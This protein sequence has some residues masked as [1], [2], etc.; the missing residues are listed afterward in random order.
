MPGDNPES[1]ALLREPVLR[2]RMSASRSKQILDAN[3]TVIGAAECEH[4]S[5]GPT[6]WRRFPDLAEQTW[7][8]RDGGGGVV[9]R[10]EGP[11]PDH[12]SSLMVT[13]KNGEEVGTITKPLTLA[14]WKR[15]DVESRGQTLGFLS[16]TLRTVYD[17][18]GRA[19][20]TI[21]KR[22]GTGRQPQP[23]EYW[24]TFRE[25]LHD[26]LRSLA[27]AAAVYCASRPNSGGGY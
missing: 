20:A 3:G 27:I 9:R 15:Y 7:A 12:P 5:S 2:V 14:F 25:P 22:Q 17:A 18:G 23:P 13:D 11:Q 24:I 6:G 21:E 19:V 4:Q 26:R 10:I 8:V 16:F 1:S